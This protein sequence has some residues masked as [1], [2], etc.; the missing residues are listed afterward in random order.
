M[1]A[2]LVRA[3]ASLFDTIGAG[4]GLSVITF[5][6]F[7]G[8]TGIGHAEVRHHIEYLARHC[9]FIA[10]A[11]LRDLA[12]PDRVAML[13]VDDCHRDIYDYL[14]PAALAHR[15]PIVICVPTDFYFRGA[16]LWFD[17]LYW[18]R[19]RAR[20]DAVLQVD[21][22]RVRLEEMAE[23]DWLKGY[24]K[25]L[26]P[27]QREPLL[28]DIA[29]QL[30]LQCPPAPQ[31]GYEAVTPGQMREM[32]A[33]GLVELCAHTVSH[34]IATVLSAARLAAEL[35]ASKREIEQLA[36]REVS[37]FCYPN[38][39][40][41]DFDDATTAAVQQAGFDCAFTS[42]A[43][44]NRPP[45]DRLRIRRVHAHALRARFEK[46]ASGLGDFQRRVFA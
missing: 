31:D 4:R 46:D 9:E 8:G 44:L 7:G 3:A 35:A 1:K 11:R 17:R 38:G 26:L 45:V 28:D 29:R 18:L 21:A 19:E 33:S 14:Y 25:R 41:G 5:H 37:S 39:E 16:W 34:T 12:A 36:G 40:A 24:L 23:L 32:L 43:G 13:T 20:H 6:R 10:P 2:T 42:V 22:R 27:E 15:A 30:G